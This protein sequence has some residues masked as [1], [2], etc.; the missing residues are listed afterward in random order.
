MFY[1][2]YPHCAHWALFVDTEFDIFTVLVVQAVFWAVPDKLL[3]VFAST[4]I[5]VSESRGTHDHILLSHDSES[6]TANRGLSAYDLL[7]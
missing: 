5:L 1:P 4:L 6:R 2:T 3:Q 7:L